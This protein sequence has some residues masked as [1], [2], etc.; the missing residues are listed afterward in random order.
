MLA[1]MERDYDM[2][3]VGGGPAGTTAALYARSAGLSVLLIDKARFPRDKVCGDAVASKSVGVLRDLGLLDELRLEPHEPIDAAVLSSPSGAI[4]RVDLNPSP[5]P[6]PRHLVCRR[7]VLDRVLF[8]A[9]RKTSDT[10][11]GRAVTGLIRDEGLVCGVEWRDGEARRRATAGVVIGADGFSS[12]VARDVGAYRYDSRRWWVATRAYY[13]GLDCAPNTAEVH[14]VA[15]TLPGFLWLFP[16]GDGVT[17]V[18]VGLVHH[19]LKRRKTGLRAVHE[20]VIS[21]P[22]FRAR[23][24][25]AEPIGTVRGWN[26]P[27]PNEARTLH[28][29]GFLLVGDAAGL[30]DPFSGE[31]IGNA[32]CSGEV[33]ARVAA[34]ACAERDFTAAR[35]AEYADSLWAALDRRELA[36]HYRLRSL[37]RH[38]RLVDL[39]IGRA[40]AHRGTPEWISSMTSGADALERKQKLVSPLT[41]IKLLFKGR[42]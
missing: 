29:G 16:T 14:Y 37:A 24:A 21:S 26:L 35:L 39:V 32:M 11:E 17:N 34:A 22:R 4:F 12:T 5:G 40:A 38:R 10:I 42:P 8:D 25:A 31:G 36:L 20:S 13:R 30:V 9:V 7:E 6:S 33:A 1:V 3:V 2:I 15:E 19:D 23:F 27:T 41:Y 18:G 28:G